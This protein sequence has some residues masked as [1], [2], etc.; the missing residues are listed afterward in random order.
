[1]K[2]LIAG[3][4]FA[5]LSA[6]A[7]A[8]E[9]A[10]GIKAW[11]QRNFTQAHQIFS[12]LA[13]AGNPEAQ[14]LLGE[15]YG[16]GEGVPEDLALAERWLGQAHA[17]GHKDAAASLGNVRQRSARKADIARYAGGVDGADLS[18]AKFG[19]AM[20]VLPEVSRTQVEIRAT[21][22]SIRQ[23]RACYERYAAH[24]GGKAIPADLA[25]LMNLV[26]LDRARGAIDKA[27]AAASREALA[28]TA[29]TDAW[30]AR[31]Q[32]HTVSMYKQQREDSERRQRELDDTQ[33]RARAAALA[34]KK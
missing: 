26:E 17:R 27:A 14:L 18:L 8:D 30:Y 16:Y 25:K 4:V 3:V 1:M 7:C 5:L 19:C 28:F 23:W 9:L 34:P 31:T 20:P 32:Q 22:A 10:D 11:E 12:T 33:Q 29:A 21:D 6:A 24:L 15:M 2:K 13:T